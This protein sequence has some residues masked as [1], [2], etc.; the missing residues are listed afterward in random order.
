MPE[1]GDLVG[2]KYRLARKIGRGGM[3]AV[4]EAVH[5]QIGK[6]VA[7]K[8]LHAG[9]DADDEL[10]A[11]FHQEAQAAAA[12]GHRGIVNIYDVGV[13]EDRAPYLVMELLE[14]QGLSDLLN[15]VERLEVPRA[16]FIICQV[17]AALS[18]AHDAGIVHRDLKPENIF[19][20]DS[21]A[22]LPEV[23]LLDFGISR[24]IAPNDPEFI[25]RMTRTGIVMGTPHYMSPEQAAGKKD[26]D[27]QTDVYSM[28]VILFQCLTG[29]LPHGGDNYNA[30]M[31]SIIADPPVAPRTFNPDLPLPLEAIILR[32]LEKARSERYQDAAEMFYDLRPF[33]EPGAVAAL[34]NP[35]SAGQGGTHG[36]VPTLRDARAEVE[37]PATAATELRDSADAVPTEAVQEVQVPTTV[38]PLGSSSRERKAVAAD[39]VPTTAAPV[40][41]PQPV[42]PEWA[43]HPEAPAAA[44]P[45][46]RSRLV[47][48]IIGVAVAVGLGGGLV[49][50]GQVYLGGGESREV[51]QPV[52]PVIP[53][54]ENGASTAPPPLPMP[55]THPATVSDAGPA[56]VDAAQA[57][58]EVASPSEP[59]S[60][61]PVKAPA[62]VGGRRAG[63]GKT[64]RV[65]KTTKAPV[66][67][68][69]GQEMIKT[70]TSPRGDDYGQEMRTKR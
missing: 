12:A 18:G 4:Y 38:D 67:A 17:L 41:A 24:I 56:Q 19:L 64:P 33:V 52:A 15:D 54:T 34:R 3:G 23:K 46:A 44:Q 61:A 59:P 16:S 1:V 39:N 27:H 63:R 14:G 36:V 35:V 2:G 62:K 25:T 31:A 50:L 21:G 29:S 37:D 26:I 48:I 28:A 11:R 43:S 53:A 8:V 47:P 68:D 9:G 30:L 40:D 20:A 6:S 42:A 55:A 22:A 70:G 7:V 60:V 32:G 49:G 65:T 69:Y 58:I 5:E 45:R 57:P 51:D 13:A 10:V 66:P